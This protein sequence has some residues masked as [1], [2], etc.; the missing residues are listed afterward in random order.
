[1]LYFFYHKNKIIFTNGFI[2]KSNRTPQREKSL[3]IERRKLFLNK[4]GD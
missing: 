3:A 4:R 1:M 2:K